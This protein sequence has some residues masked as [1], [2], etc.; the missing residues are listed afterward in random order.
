MDLFAADGKKK[1][2]VHRKGI[3][4]RECR[5]TFRTK[6]RSDAKQETRWGPK[7][8]VSQATQRDLKGGK[9]AICFEKGF[10][11][12]EAGK[13]DEDGEKAG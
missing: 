3:A 4:E 9:R 13:G 5:R 7:S 6:P 11:K 2:E 10:R 8:S 12:W 1:G